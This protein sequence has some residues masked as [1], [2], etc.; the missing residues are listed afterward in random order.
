VDRALDARRQA[1]MVED[2]TLTRS[3]AEM[4]FANMQDYVTV[5]P[6][7]TAYVDLNSLSRSQFA[8]IQEINTEEVMEGRGEDGR[9]I[10]KVK[11]KLHERCKA[12]ELLMRKTGLLKD[13]NV[14]VNVLVGIAER[15]ADAKKS[16][17]EK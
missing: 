14:Q 2:A 11:I 17:E 9:T 3:L 12:T 13:N 7:G 16:L 5:Q 15:L 8:A 10:R 6:D 1:L 4:A